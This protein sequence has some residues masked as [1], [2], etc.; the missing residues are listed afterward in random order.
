MKKILSLCA[1]AIVVLTAHAAPLLQQDLQL[2][3]VLN[4]L[5][6][7]ALL[8]VQSGATLTNTG[9]L[10][11]AGVFNFAS[12]TVT[13]PASVSGGTTSF[14]P[15][16]GDL[17]SIAALTTT[18]YGRSVLSLADAA[19]GRTLFGMV[20]GTDVQAYD[21]DLAAI[22]ALTTTTNGRSLL[23]ASALT[24][25][26]LGLT[27]GAA[28]DTIGGNGSAYYLSRSNHTGTQPMSTISDAGTAAT[29]NVGTASGTV[30]A[31]DDVRLVSTYGPRK[32]YTKLYNYAAGSGTQ[33]VRTLTFGDSLAFFK[34]QF[35]LRYLDAQLGGLSGSTG[36]PTG[37]AAYAGSGGGW[38]SQ[39]IIAGTFATNPA[40]G[41]T[42]WPTG[43]LSQ[44]TTSSRVQWITGGVTPLFTKL[45]V[46]YVRESGAGIFLVKVGGSTVATLNASNASVAL[47]SYEITQSIAAATVELT[48]SSGGNVRI[49]GV[50]FSE[51]AFNGINNLDVSVGGLALSN[52][53]SSSQARALFTAFVAD[54]AP[55]MMFVEMDD[56]ID[57]TDGARLADCLDASATGDKVIIAST[58][59]AADPTL[60]TRRDLWKA[61]VATRNRTFFFFD[62]WTPVSPHQVLVDLGWQGDG[63]HPGY[64]CSAYLS[65]LLMDQLGL[66]NMVYGKSNK[67]LNAAYTGVSRLQRN[68]EF[69][70]AGEKLAFESDAT[71]GYDW[72]MTIPRAFT[73]STRGSYG[74][75]NA[76]LMQIAG[77]A[78][79]TFLP[80]GWL[81]GS[82]T[83]TRSVATNSSSGFNVMT[84]LDSAKVNGY[85]EVMFNMRLPGHTVAQLTGGSYNSNSRGGALV[86]V[87]NGSPTGTNALAWARDGQGPQEWR[88]IVDDGT[89]GSAWNA[90]S[91]A[92][93]G[94]GATTLTG[95]L[96]GNGTSAITGI[97][98]TVI[99]KLR[100]GTATL[101]SGTV[102]VS[103]AN[104][105]ASTRI[106][107]NRFTDGG[108]LGDSY[109]VTRSAGA[110]F[111]I[112]S[113]TANA[114]VAG[115]TSTVAY[116]AIEP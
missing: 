12:G 16:D 37:A 26:G 52:A 11:G 80:N 56:Q 60:A 98:G 30:M 14:Q 20:I 10:N 93:G 88:R 42:Y 23:T 41:Y 46:Y 21:S 57:P 107:V 55:D 72:N 68:S 78:L 69:V 104:T 113:K 94:T 24:A 53:M 7:G 108:T 17:D 110:S 65:D 29:K 74:T 4:Q 73:I 115:D 87:T 61:L 81:W 100:H 70:A 59:S 32:I 2:S 63:T 31:G 111:T 84:F 5:K 71:F 83:S 51:T 95:L 90:F 103:D 50:C 86:Y 85:D 77:S 48:H 38:L 54:W 22:A 58:P 106:F 114:T 76:A 112:T 82:A 101:V 66:K 9:T 6:T 39:N 18:S 3:G 96:Y 92:K 49:I 43:Q 116:L 62:G 79:P 40:D 47:G 28:L 44:L 36:V 109:S 105:T 35:V 19:A 33:S 25:A 64:Q 99:T 97:P 45:K 8:T 91:V 15:R 89:I 67:S 13:L 75:P 1:L 27:N 34:P 102:T